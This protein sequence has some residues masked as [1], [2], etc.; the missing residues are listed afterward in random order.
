MVNSTLVTKMG[1]EQHMNFGALFYIT[2]AFQ[3]KSPFYKVQFALN[4]N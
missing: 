3:Q 2:L 1:L 4:C